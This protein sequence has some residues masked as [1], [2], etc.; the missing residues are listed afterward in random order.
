MEFI[1]GGLI[2]VAGLV[3]A[4]AGY[5]RSH[6]KRQL[7]YRVD[8]A[9]LLSSSKAADTAL[10]VSWGGQAVS[11]P[12]IVTIELWSSGRADIPSSR[13]DALAPLEF[14]LGAQ[15]IEEV[16]TAAS[17]P[18]FDHVSDSGI[19]MRPRLVPRKF[20]ARSQYV[21]ASTPSV[22]LTRQP[23]IDVDVVAVEQREVEQK[24]HR[25]SRKMWPLVAGIA[26]AL[27]V[28]GFV[29]VGVDVA[30]NGPADT[31]GA[32]TSTGAL[33]FLLCG[34]TAIVTLVVALVRWIV[35]LARN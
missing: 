28:I 19:A 26:G 4:V 3:I 11:N 32:L 8:T 1:F 13:F 14:D 17:E 25:Q 34:A 15:I 22:R 2:P 30:I 5:L 27:S 23:I 33:L 20:R 29:L 21:V 9:A 31:P 24:L 7:R 35:G 10:E 6:P 12:H 16:Q 18:A